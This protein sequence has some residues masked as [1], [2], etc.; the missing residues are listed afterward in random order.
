MFNSAVV[1]IILTTNMGRIHY[2]YNI[3]QSCLGTHSCYFTL[4][5]FLHSQVWQ[6]CE[7]LE[8]DLE[9]WA[10]KLVE[11]YHVSWCQVSRHWTSPYQ[12]PHGFSHWVLHFGWTSFG[13]PHTSYIFMKGGHPTCPTPSYMSHRSVSGQL[14]WPMGWKSLFYFQ[15]YLWLV[16][17]SKAD[18][19]LLISCHRSGW[20]Q[21]TGLLGVFPPKLRPVH[22]ACILSKILMT[23]LRGCIFYS[24][25]CIHIWIYT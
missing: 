23:C 24:Y 9:G 18:W 12:I 6:Q 7:F 13:D 19:I 15:K 21:W 22:P 14:I 25:T 11:S 5:P 17:L 4:S 8:A 1:S 3:C 20:W 16:K 2:N 10:N